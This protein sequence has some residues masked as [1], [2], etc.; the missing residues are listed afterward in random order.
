MEAIIL[1]EQELQE[2]NHQ[3]HHEEFVLKTN[4][5][6]NTIE[7]LEGEI[8]DNIKSF[9]RDG[10]ERGLH[11]MNTYI[12]Q[13]EKIKTNF[14]QDSNRWINQNHIKTTDDNG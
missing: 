8:I 4:S 10:N 6:M 5:L 3:Y 11:L 12:T 13:I 14:Q 9:S 1:D 2:S 7:T